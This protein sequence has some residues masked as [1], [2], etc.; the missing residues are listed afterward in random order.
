MQQFY[1]DINGTITNDLIIKAIVSDARFYQQDGL[2]MQSFFIH[3]IGSEVSEAVPPGPSSGHGGAGMPSCANPHDLLGQD[4]LDGG[5]FYGDANSASDGSPVDSSYVQ[6]HVQAIFTDLAALDAE[7]KT[8][9][10]GVQ[11]GS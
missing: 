4:N 1:Q 11:V 10:P 8:T 9:A 6:S 7:L 5:T 3:A 2:A